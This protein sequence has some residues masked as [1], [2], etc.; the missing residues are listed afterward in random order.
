MSTLSAW[1][2]MVG[3]IFSPSSY[4][5]P[6][7]SQNRDGFER[8]LDVRMRD[9]YSDDL[10]M[11]LSAVWACVR[12]LAETISTLPLN[13]WETA[14]DGTRTLANDHPLAPLLRV[15]PNADMTAQ[16]YWEAYCAAMIL[17]G[18]GYGWKKRVGKRIVSLEFLPPDRVTW[19]RRSDGSKV[20]RYTQKTGSV[21][22]IDEADIFHTL[23]FTLDGQCGLSPIRYGARVFLSA[24]S[25]DTAALETF[26]NGLMPTVGFSMERVLSKP[27]RAEFRDEFL[28]TVGGAM[29][30]GKPFLLEGGMTPHAIGIDPGDAQLLE[31]RA[32]SVEEICR[33]FRVPPF[34]VGHSEKSTSWGTGIE[35]QTIGFAT[36]ALRPWLRRIENSI[37]RSLFD[38]DRNRFHAEFAIEG[39][40]RGDSAARASFY[41][42]AG[43]NGW[44]TRD[45]I[46]RL[47][48]LP[49][50]PGGDQVTV[51]SNLV[52][53]DKLGETA[54]A[55]TVDPVPVKG[56]DELAE[57]V[58]WLVER[59]KTTPPGDARRGA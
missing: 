59:V 17:R 43:Q 3:S 4:P 32:W 29:N 52:P 11:R 33:W 5:F 39:L 24:I 51:Q 21:A 44:M 31:S 18:D 28:A 19:E 13:V 37:S 9:C 30:A 36:F 48:N 12:L 10:A 23:G 57:Q 8:N 58:R 40:L 42:S 16:S 54:P 45:E 47:E 56:L 34:M 50:V 41:A 26:Q 46:R 22:I 1:L 15:Q 38:A 2:G 49:P 27:Q 20:Y 7:G 55:M 35:Q 14:P 53:L 6:T 25:A